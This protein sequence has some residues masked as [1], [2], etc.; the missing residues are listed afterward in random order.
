MDDYE[1]VLE[2]CVAQLPGILEKVDYAREKQD[3]T[4]IF[5]YLTDCC[6]MSGAPAQGSP[7]DS[8]LVRL[9]STQ[10]RA[11]V[12]MLVEYNR[13]YAMDEEEQYRALFLDPVCSTLEN[14]VFE[15]D[16]V[17]ECV[18]N[19]IAELFGAM[20][21]VPYLVSS[22]AT[23]QLIVFIAVLRKFFPSL[24]TSPP[25]GSPVAADQKESVADRITA[26]IDSVSDPT[27]NRRLKRIIQ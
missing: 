4:L 1:E 20:L 26:I 14:I 23:Q 18:D 22:S 9:V 13:L 5:K 19:G 12:R 25:S 10:A 17:E 15:E 27:C 3:C 21:D 6:M 7:L 8:V 24:R 11:F 16:L 2:G